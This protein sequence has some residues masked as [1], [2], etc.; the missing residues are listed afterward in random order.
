MGLVAIL[1]SKPA[2]AGL[3]INATWGSGAQAFT[4][5]QQADIQSAINLYEATFSNNVTVNITFNNMSSGLGQSSSA[6]YSDQYT[7]IL[8]RL[9]ANNAA[10]PSADTTAAIAQLL[11]HPSGITTNIDLSQ[12]N[13]KALGVSES[14]TDGTI[15]LNAGICFS[16]HSSPV[17]GQYDLYA[18]ACHEMDE[19]LGTVSGSGDA[20]MTTADLFRYSGTNV[21]DF[22]AN[23]SV[24]N[25]FSVNGTNM[26]DEYNNFNHAAGDWGD[27]IIHSPMQ[28]QDYAGTPG[29][30]AN[31][32]NELRLLNVVG[33]ELTPST[34]EPITMGI[35]GVGAIAL[36]KRRMRKN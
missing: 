33:W 2:S 30:A 11:A 34:P 6:F 10:D 25:Y 26:L 15:G 23:S 3:T 21:R 20:N 18:V 7:D 32:V 31:P 35:F 13:V 1:G 22:S 14:G 36:L 4:A 17:A 8:A 24:H 9:E 28:V 12:A 5:A 19:V 29:S 27:W 16:T